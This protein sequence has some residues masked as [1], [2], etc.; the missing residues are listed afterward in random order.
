MAPGSRQ[1]SCELW[2]PRSRFPQAAFVTPKCLCANKGYRGYTNCFPFTPHTSPQAPK[3][4]FQQP[5]SIPRLPLHRGRSEHSASFI[6]RKCRVLI[7]GSVLT[8]HPFQGGSQGRAGPEGPRGLCW[9]A[10]APSYMQGTPHIWDA[11]TCAMREGSRSSGH[12]SPLA[13]GHVPPAGP[14]TAQLFLAPKPVPT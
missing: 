12:R 5:Q 6:T 8:H 13:P 4:D 10:G 3:A 1:E 7:S 11:H 9:G 14:G 2:G